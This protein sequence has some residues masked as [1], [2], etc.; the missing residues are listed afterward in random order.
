MS[1]LCRYLA[2]LTIPDKKIYFKS[3][4]YQKEKAG[5]KHAFSKRKIKHSVRRR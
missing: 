2:Q 5:I 1:V 3:I 4:G